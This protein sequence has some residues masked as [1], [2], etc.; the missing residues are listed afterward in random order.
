MESYNVL[1][2]RSESGKVW[3]C[4]RFISGHTVTCGIVNS[5][6]QHRTRFDFAEAP[7]II[8][9]H[10]RSGEKF[11]KDYFHVEDAILN[12]E[13][14]F[15]FFRLLCAVPNVCSYEVPR[16]SRK[17]DVQRVVNRKLSR[18]DCSV[19]AIHVKRRKQALF[20]PVS[21]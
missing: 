15:S 19:Q 14:Y 16:S 17:T 6:A 20:A 8:G 21:F 9:T 12:Y 4:F 7:R 10:A 5:A 11:S 3:R 13:T 2:N 18:Q 1:R